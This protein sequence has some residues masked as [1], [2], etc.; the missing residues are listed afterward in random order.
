MPR[1]P[2]CKEELEEIIIFGSMVCL[3]TESYMLDKDGNYTRFE[4][5]DRD[6]VDWCFDHAE[7]PHCGAILNVKFEKRGEVK[8]LEE[9][10]DA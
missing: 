9:D 4:E 8:L 3:T 7:C 6:G 10:E 5:I 2:V 1:C